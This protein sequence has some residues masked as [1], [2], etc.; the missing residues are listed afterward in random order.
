MSET[1]LQAADVYVP[2][3][4]EVEHALM[5]AVPRQNHAPDGHGSHIRLDT[6]VHGACS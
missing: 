6:F 1:L 5:T 2:G 3:A 4:H